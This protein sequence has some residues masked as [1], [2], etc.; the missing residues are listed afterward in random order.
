MA[1]KV[2]K[3]LWSVVKIKLYEG[4]KEFMVSCEDKII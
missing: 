2:A 1:T 4:G 3:N